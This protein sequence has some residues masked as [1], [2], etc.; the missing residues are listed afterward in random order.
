MK[1]LYNH[2]RKYSIN[3]STLTQDYETLSLS[4]EMKVLKWFKK[5]LT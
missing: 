5:A 3:S 4:S 2:E 1:I